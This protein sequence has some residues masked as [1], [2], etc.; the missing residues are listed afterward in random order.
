[1][2]K[3]AA[4]SPP[5]DQ[6]MASPSSSRAVYVPNCTTTL[7]PE[8]SAS[9]SISAKFSAAGPPVISGVSSTLVTV[10]A[11]V[12]L[13]ALLD[14]PWPSSAFTMMLYS[15]L[16]PLSAGCSKSGRR[17]KLRTPVKGSM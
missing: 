16:E 8:V 12:K 15:L 9:Y 1:M 11:T 4:S 6:V 13:P 14:S 3:S 17:P 7:A 5:S 10:T 2:V